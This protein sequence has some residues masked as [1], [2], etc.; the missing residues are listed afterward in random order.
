MLENGD[1]V[2]VI[3]RKQFDGDKIRHFVGEVIDS[4]DMAMKVRGYA[5]VHDD[6]TNEY[7]RRNDIRTRIISLVDAA[8]IIW[9]IPKEVIVE[10][11]HIEINQRNHRIITDNDSLA[12]N[13]SE[14]WVSK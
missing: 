9:V 12:M 4:S 7:V 8:N 13:L 1:K 6:F 11:V 10:N 5:F 14:F 3:T 2:F